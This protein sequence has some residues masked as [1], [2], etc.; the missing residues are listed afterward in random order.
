V[1]SLAKLATDEHAP[2]Q[3]T[4]AVT[5]VSNHRHEYCGGGAFVPSYCDMFTTFPWLSSRAG[6]PALCTRLSVKR[7]RR[8]LRGAK[9]CEELA[10]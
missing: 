3:S 2:A 6:H 4:N 9:H 7:G 5:P 10:L 1:H 8:G